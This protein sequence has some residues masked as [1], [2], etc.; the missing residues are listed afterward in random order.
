MKSKP[1]DIRVIGTEL[2]F[3]PIKTRMPLKF[4]SETLSEV[5]CA[6]AKVSVTDQKGRVA[7]GWGETPLSVQWVWPSHLSYADRR[8]A[9]CQFCLRIASEMSHFDY[10]GHPIEIG[11][12]FQTDVL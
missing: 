4:G 11:H 6:R 2:Y 10:A 5:A 7:T 1:T 9:L 8:Q 12:A 3:L